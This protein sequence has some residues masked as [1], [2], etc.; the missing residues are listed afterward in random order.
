MNSEIK[1]Y[2]GYIALL[3]GALGFIWLGAEKIT[4]HQ[5]ADLYTGL[6]NPTE[7]ERFVYQPICEKFGL[8]SKIFQKQK[9]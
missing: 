3:Y 7:L 2:L 6:R 1:S 8:E 5:S 9:E 4:G